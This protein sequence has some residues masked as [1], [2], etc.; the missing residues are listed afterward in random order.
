M[1][2][3]IAE[4]GGNKLIEID[5]RI[6]APAAFRSFRPTPANVSFFYENGVRLF[7]ML[8]SGLYSCLGTHYSLYGEI[9]KGDG[10]YDFSAFD[11]Q[12]EMFM[13]FAPEGYFCVMI[14]LDTREWFMKK[15]NIPDSFRKFGIACFYDEWKKAAKEYLKAFIE[16]AE[17]KYGERIFAYSF[18]SGL[19][20]EWFTAD[21]GEYDKVKEIA[22]KKYMGDDKVRIPSQDELLESNKNFLRDINSTIANYY[23]FTAEKTADTVCEFAKAAQEVIK[24]NKLI[25]LFYGYMILDSQKQNKWGTGMYERVWKCQDIDMIFSPAAYR[26]FRKTENPAAY[27]VAVDS[28]RINDKLYMHEIDHRTHLSK[29][30]LEN[31]VIIED[32][33]DTEKET[34]M[35]L[36]R[37]LCQ[38]LQK[39]AALWWFDFT[40]GYYFTHTYDKEINTAVKIINKLKELPRKSVADVAVFYD[41]ESL[42][43]LNEN[44]GIKENYVNNQILELAKTGVLYDIYNLNDIGKINIKQYKL[45]IFLDAFLLSD[46]IL[47]EIEKIKCYKLW[48][49]APGYVKNHKS[50]DVEKIIGMKLSE[51][52]GNAVVN[53]D[54]VMFG[55]DREIS[56]IFNVEN[57][58]NVIAYFDGTD[59]A[60][61][62]QKGEN[63]YCSCG[64]IPYELWCKFEEIGKVHRYTHNKTAVYGDSRFICCQNAFSDNCEISLEEDG[65]YI[66]LFDG[67]EYKT[68]NKIL[69]YKTPKGT[70]KMF[71]LKK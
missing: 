24:H 19:A 45:I 3:R 62:G 61:V 69:K 9:W 32:G 26:D 37:E 1:K 50:E 39:G 64:N 43:Y 13:K 68:Q 38:M 18:S 7:Q 20:T 58:D 17:E 52:S 56:P 53:Y 48:I 54:G 10:E 31:G 6:Y 29:Y 22:Y 63:I 66:E 21:M 2:S 5:G 27:Q 28:I 57:A 35:I 46:N 25:G 11:K 67:G 30:P 47:E 33:Y 55:F 41:S 14:Q 49:H 51:F 44:L 70:T 15:Y 36:R 42:F 65:E 60:A 23:K 16:Y 59:K 40:G 4:H 34:V 71:L 12:M 8:C